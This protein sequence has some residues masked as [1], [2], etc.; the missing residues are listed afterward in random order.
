MVEIIASETVYRGKAFDVR[1]DHLLFS[2]GYREDLDIV[3]HRESVILIPVDESGD[4]WFI[5]QYR[6]ATGQEL[7]ELPA[8]VMEAG[9]IPEAT[10]GREIRE[11][12][13]MAAGQLQRLG[14]FFLAP[15]YTTENMYVFLATKLSYS[16]LNPD[17]GEVIN[18]VKL[19]AGEATLM[20][21]RGQIHDAKSLAAL[22]LARPHLAGKPGM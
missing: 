1:K 2:S 13:G 8:G 6:H 19:P 9:E 21:E 10:A 11:E 20:A 14:S 17:E 15:G 3:V 7:L 12:I 16:P 18:I 4:I 22:L 5:R